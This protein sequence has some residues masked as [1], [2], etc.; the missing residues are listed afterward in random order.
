LATD[1]AE[2]LYRSAHMLVAVSGSLGALQV[3]RLC[4]RLQKAAATRDMAAAH[5]MF[6]EVDNAIDRALETMSA[7]IDD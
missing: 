7:M 5:D 1:D 6:A 2:I 4:D 3:S